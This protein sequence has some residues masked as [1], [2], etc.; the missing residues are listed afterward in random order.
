MQDP[1]QPSSQAPSPE[2]EAKRTASF[3]ITE[4]DR[5]LRSHSLTPDDIMA[6]ESARN[7]VQVEPQA[8]RRRAATSSRL[9]SARIRDYEGD[10]R[11]LSPRP[12]STVGRGSY[13]AEDGQINPEE[14]GRAITSDNVSQHRK[15]RSMSQLQAVADAQANVRRRSDEIRYWRQS[16]DQGLGPPG[17]SHTNDDFH[18]VVVNPQ[19]E[20]PEETQP[21]TPPQ[22]FTFP[23]TDMKITQAASLEDRIAALEDRNQ[24]LEKV[25]SHL[26]QAVPGFQHYMGTSPQATP[27]PEYASGSPRVANSSL[28]A[29]G[30]E[31]VRS[32]SRQSGDSFGDEQTFVGSVPPSMKPTL[33][34]TSTV[35]LRG[36]V[37]EPASLPSLP[38]E[39]SGSFVADHY[40]TMKALIETETAARQALESQ[41]V[42]LTHRLNRM[43]RASRQ[44]SSAGG[45]TPGVYSTFEHDEE[46]EEPATAVTD[47][48]SE[49]EAFGTPHE[50]RPSS[51][52]GAFHDEQNREEE[53][54]DESQ[55]KAGRTL[56]L[57]QLTLRKPPQSPPAVEVNP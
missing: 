39:V 47:T 15:S 1:P 31:E 17:S 7:S 18:S 22:P 20:S 55:L 54:H 24:K 38:K 16:Y 13:G 29:S 49:S 25:I 43:S 26:Y 42:K 48:Y 14:V 36:T 30:A 45:I 34:P 56:S 8:N 12:A 32:S 28:G 2:G 50:E 51:G 6:I 40:T 44:L 33:R 19:E 10:L 53:Q 37:N 57:G 9:L 11:G 3:P 5:A 4:Y 21:Q 46:E 35:T 23:F 41:V 52:L 27:G